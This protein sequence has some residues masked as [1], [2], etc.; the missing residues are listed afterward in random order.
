MMA[1][2]I[3]PKG[4]EASR[5]KTYMSPAARVRR[6]NKRTSA[7]IVRKN[8]AIKGTRILKAGDEPIKFSSLSQEREAARARMLKRKYALTTRRAYGSASPSPIR[9]TYIKKMTPMP[10]S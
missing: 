7:I 1:K 10:M 8:T 5:R 3:S 2:I 6:G 4:R 9:R